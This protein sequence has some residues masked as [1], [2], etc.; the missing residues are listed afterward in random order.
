M[1]EPEFRKEFK[2]I[3]YKISSMENSLNDKIAS[4][5]KSLKV[6]ETKQSIEVWIIRTL[7]T[8][9]LL[10]GGWLFKFAHLPKI[11]K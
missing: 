3:H 2:D 8:T 9:I 1:I 10:V 4:I 5:D 6:L 11:F 7:I